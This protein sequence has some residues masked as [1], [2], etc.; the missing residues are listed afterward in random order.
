MGEMINQ[1]KE[2]TINELNEKFILN[3]NI[4]EGILKKVKPSLNKGSDY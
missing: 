4:T 3:N 2:I 1:A